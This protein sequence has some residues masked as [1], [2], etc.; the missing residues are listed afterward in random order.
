M[1]GVKICIYNTFFTLTTSHK[2]DIESKIGGLIYFLTGYKLEYNPYLR[3]AKR[4]LDRVYYFKDNRRN[5]FYFPITAL[6][7]CVKELQS[8]GIKLESEDF[9]LATDIPIKEMT[10]NLNGKFT[11]RDYQ[12]LYIDAITNPDSPAYT[13]VDLKPGAGKT[14]ISVNAVVKMKYKTAIILLPKYIEKWINDIQLY[15]DTPTERVFVVQGGDSLKKLIQT[16]SDNYD[17]I[18]FSMRTMSNFIK[19]YEDG[20]EVPIAPYSLFNKLNIGT[21]LSDESHQELGALSKI[22]MYSNVK[23]VLGLSATFISNNA[24]ERRF[25][26]VLFPEETRISNLVKF[27][28]YID[29]FAVGY[30]TSKNLRLKDKGPQGYSHILYEQCLMMQKRAIK[31]YFDMVEYYIQ[32]GYIDRKRKGDKCLVFFA[33][34]AMCTMASKYFQNKFKN[35]K[36]K[37]YVGEDDYQNLME[38]DI[39]FS[40]VLSS[41]TAVDIPNLITVIQTISIGSAKANVQATGRLR[42]INDMDTQYY[43]LYCKNSSN[44]VKLHKTRENAISHMARIYKYIDYYKVL[45]SRE[46]KRGL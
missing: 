37:R 41:G 40:T 32:S 44:Q 42:K 35:L 7:R 22:V 31:D 25:Q 30:R 23:K 13:L 3:R 45:G 1:E 4:V 8:K 16:G 27:D 36:I 39:I 14:F 24:D 6:V 15:T 20:K 33:T 5:I 34:I 29:I 28:K 18:I 38:G 2:E 17:F 21:L 10:C 9:I 11:P 12:E 19:D 46:E 26:S 43:Y